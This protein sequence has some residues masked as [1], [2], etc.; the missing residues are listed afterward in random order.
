[1]ICL[2]VA[3]LFLGQFCLFLGGGFW[4]CCILS[5]IYARVDYEGTQRL[6]A[7]RTYIHACASVNGVRLQSF[8]LNH[9]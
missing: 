2:V 8:Y 9:A 4:G 3:L 5:F 7:V 6:L 1:M